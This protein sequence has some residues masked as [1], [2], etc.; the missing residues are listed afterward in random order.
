MNDLFL[1]EIVQPDSRVSNSSRSA[2]RAERAERDRKRRRRRRRNLTALVIVLLVLGGAGYA[3]VQRGIPLFNSL[4]AGGEEAADDYPGPGA[5][6]VDVVIPA[7]ATGADMALIL[8]EADVVAST[9]AFTHAFAANPDASS[10][11][12]GTYRLVLQMRASDAVAALLNPESKVQTQ[13]TIAEGLRFDQIMEK[14]TS[15]TA[16][17]LADFQAAMADPAAVGLPAEAGGN[18]EGWL[19]PSTYT[20]EPGTEPAQMIT[21]MIAKTVAVLDAQGVAP[22]D[23]MRVL[24]IA[25]L[26]ERESPDPGVSPMMA[27][28]IQNRLD[29]DMKLD[30]DASVAYGLNKSG[31]ELTTAD[32]ADATNPY[33]TYVHPGLPPGPI[34]SPGEAS[35]DA[36]LHP[37]DGPWR[38]W[39]T[40]NLDTK[41]TRFAETFDEQLQNQELLREW[42]AANGG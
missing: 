13:V 39:V 25:S 10:I 5:T 4:G 40:I 2:R 27:R 18:F 7:G 42:Q 15:V 28:A 9:R 38:F 23:R 1:D 14:L 20:F 30:I 6:A 19:F 26:V 24:T 29:I 8:Y 36:V 16:V 41:E 22:A 33:N 3:V 31:T 17:P 37:A 21:T 35:I 34:A 12:P 11:Q 32:L